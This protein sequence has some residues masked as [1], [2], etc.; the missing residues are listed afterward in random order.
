MGRIQLG[1]MPAWKAARR[2]NAERIWQVAHNCPGLRVP[3]IPEHIEH[4]EIDKT[5]RVIQ[6][7]MSEAAG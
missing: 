1:G 3:A 4:A 6:A 7:V 2:A 5:C